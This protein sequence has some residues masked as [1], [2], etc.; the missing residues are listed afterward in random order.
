[1]AYFTSVD[2]GKHYIAL[3]FSNQKSDCSGT[4][5]ALGKIGVFCTSALP[6]LAIVIALASVIEI[7]TCIGCFL[8]P[9]KPLAK[10]SFFVNWGQ[11]SVSLVVA[12]LCAFIVSF[13]QIHAL[14][15]Q[16]FFRGP[17]NSSF[18]IDWGRSV[19]MFVI[20]VLFS[21]NGVFFTLWANFSPE[22][23]EDYGEMSN[24]GLILSLFFVI[25]VPGAFRLIWLF[26]LRGVGKVNWS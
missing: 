9:G 21:V 25:L 19:S 17:R 2:S 12:V 20:N 1:M 3:F 15:N 4:L 5:F 22:L 23:G 13:S 7:V 10:L 14:R 24:L 16:D 6:L 8:L 26:G 18:K 11:M